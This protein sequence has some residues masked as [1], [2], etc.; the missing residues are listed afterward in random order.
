TDGKLN[1]TIMA[2]SG[3][4]IHKIS[5][6]E[7]GDYTLNGAGTT[8]TNANVGASFIMQVIAYDVPGINPAFIVGNAT[9]TPSGGTYDAV[10]DPH[11]PAAIWF[12]SAM[13]DVDAQL[14]AQGILA[15]ATKILFAM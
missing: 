9:F 4:A 3:K 6:N 1:S 15:H 12:G 7:F 13:F 10:N 8:G 5:L 14:A 2:L 11:G